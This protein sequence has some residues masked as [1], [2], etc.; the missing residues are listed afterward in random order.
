M[1]AMVYW[2]TPEGA[3]IEVQNPLSSND[4]SDLPLAR[5][6]G[7]QKG[8]QMDKMEKLFRKVMQI[9]LDRVTLVVGSKS[10]DLTN[11]ADT[12]I[13]NAAKSLEEKLERQSPRQEGL[14]STLITAK[15]VATA[16]AVQ[17]I[18]EMLTSRK[19]EK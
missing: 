8:D 6:G 9:I 7:R 19:M 12:L 17:A 5:A 1:G 18:H 15:Y 11:K 10:G 16:V 3:E 14:R 4:T 13:K 2:H